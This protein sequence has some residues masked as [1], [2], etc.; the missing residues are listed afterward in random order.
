MSSLFYC[1]ENTT[2]WRCAWCKKERDTGQCGSYL[3]VAN[4]AIGIV[5]T[6]KC[7]GE[8]EAAIVQRLSEAPAAT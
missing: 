5:C 8:A 7:E 1:R 6:E 4:I 3:K 2:Y